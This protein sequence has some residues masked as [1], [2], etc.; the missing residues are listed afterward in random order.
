M[1]WGSKV[2]GTRAGAQAHILREAGPA[3]LVE[4]EGVCLGLGG[5][6]RV[7]SRRSA[8]CG[9]WRA[10]GTLLWIEVTQQF[11]QSWAQGP[12]LPLGSRKVDGG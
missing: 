10:M 4:A 3:L 11:D 5:P 7:T 2:W 9:S 12:G 1:P 8:M 6:A